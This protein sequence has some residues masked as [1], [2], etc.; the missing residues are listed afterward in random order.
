M[1][2]SLGS[3]AA[4]AEVDITYST[5]STLAISTSSPLPG[6]TVGHAYSKTLTATG[7]TGGYTWAL[8][9]G[10]ALNAGL[11]LSTGGVISGTPTVNFTRTFTI[12]VTDSAL[13][14]ADKTFSLTIGAH[15]TP[16]D[17]SVLLS[18]DGH[19]RHDHRGTY[20]I[21]VAN[22][23][24]TTATAMTSVSLLLPSGITVVHGGSGTFWQCHKHAH[25]SFCSRNAKISAHSSTTITVTVRI[26]AS[27]GNVLKAKAVVTPSDSTE[28]D[29][30]DTDIA[31]VRS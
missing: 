25:S 27:V 6:G 3:T 29:N 13:N 20:K 4:A 7:G 21:L 19:F 22:T 30:T 15:G 28:S 8:I 24:T 1:G 17:L 5:S 26:T 12:E 10:S 18:H 23:G 11:S 14:T 9:P 31:I 16:G 2:T